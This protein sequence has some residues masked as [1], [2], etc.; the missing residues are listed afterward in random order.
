VPNAFGLL[1]GSNAVPAKTLEATDGAKKKV[2]LP[3]LL[4]YKYIAQSFSSDRSFG[5][6]G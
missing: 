6:I 1:D 4:K 2:A 5:R 3:N